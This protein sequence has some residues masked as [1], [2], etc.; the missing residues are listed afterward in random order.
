MGGMLL[1]GDPRAFGDSKI[2]VLFAGLYLPLQA[3]CYGDSS[4]ALGL[5]RPNFSS[6]L[7]Q[8]HRLPSLEPPK[9]LLPQLVLLTQE[10]QQVRGIHSCLLVCDHRLELGNHVPEPKRFPHALRRPGL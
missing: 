3:S 5:P 2:L 4:F 6:L 10:I 1:H 9:A 8:S 7:I